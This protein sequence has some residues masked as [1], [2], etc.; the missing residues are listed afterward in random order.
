MAT[1]RRLAA[2]FAADVAG[3]SRLMEAD[4]DGTHN[5]LKGLRCALVDPRINEHRGRVVKSTGDGFLAEFASIID[6]VR[7]AVEMQRALAEHNIMAP[8]GHQIEFRVGIN[9]GDI[10]VEE[11]D[12]Y[13]DGVNVAARLEALAD[14]GGICVSGV[15]RDQVENKLTLTFEDMGEQRVKN[16]ARPVH[17]HRIRIDE[18]VPAKE[19]LPSLSEPPA[20]S[21]KGSA[22]DND[23]F[24]FGPFRLLPAQRLLLR[25][26]GEPPHVGSR[27]LDLLIALVERAGET[28]TK[29]ELI[30]RAWP[31][32]R[33]DEGGLRVH[34]AALRRALGDGRAGNRYII[35]NPGRGYTFVAPVKRKV[36]RS[37]D[38]AAGGSIAVGN[39]PLP[40]T[41]MVGRDE[42]V[43]ALAAQ[44]ARRRFLSIIGPGGIGKTT[45]AVAVAAAG[46]ASYADGVWFVGLASLSDPELV[47]SA[48]SQVLG[49]SPSGAN[50]AAGVAAWLRDKQSLI[51]LDN[52]EHVID[53]AAAVAEAVLRTAP[54]VRILVTSREPLR[55][56]GEWS[57]RLTSLA[58]P[59]DSVD[60]TA[61]EALKYS[62]VQLFNERAMAAAD[63]F[64]L[65][66][67][68]V[69]AVLEICRR[70]D[71]LPL[72]LELAAA[73]IDVFG[74]RELAAHLDDRFRLLTSGRRTALSRHQTLGAALDWSYQLLSEA[75]RGLLRRLSLF[76]GDFTL[77]AAIAIAADIAPSEVVDHIGSLVAKSLVVVDFRNKLSRYRLLDT[78]R[79]YSRDKL[80][81]CGEL[82][83]VARRHA[84]HYCD[85]FAPAEAESETR[86]QSEW[87][88]IYGPQLDNV[89]AALD[90]AFSADGDLQLGVALTVAAVPLWEQLS[91][92]AE[93]RERVERALAVL[94]GDRVDTARSRMQLSAAH[95]W[96]LM[97]GVGRAREAGPAWT[98][99]LDLAE[100]L[101]DGSY[102]LRALWSLCIDQ[103]NN[104]DLRSALDFA[105]RFASLASN[106][107]DA[108]DLMMAD[109]LLATAQHYFGDQ[110]EAHFHIDR[111]LAQLAALAQQPQ[112]VRVRFDMRVSTHYFQARIL[113]LRGLPDQ[114]QRV[115]AHNIEEG[116]AVG[117][118]L[119][120]CSV[121]GQG[122]CPIALWAGDLAAAARYA[123]MLLHHTERHPIRLWNIWARCFIGLVHAKSGDLAEGVQALRRGFEDAGDA[124]F[125]PRFLL[126]QGEFAICLG[127]AGELA[128]GLAIIDETLARCESREELWYMAELLR[129]KGEL[130]KLQDGAGAEAAAEGYFQ[131]ALDRAGRQGAL[132]LELR[133][134]TSLARLR[135]D[136]QRIAEGRDLL[137]S[138]YRRFTEGFATTDLRTAELLLG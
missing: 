79:L 29:D 6:A 116:N 112:I 51:V 127:Q 102:R 1:T 113:W 76:A 89:R 15:V 114:A 99:T 52:C 96:S 118:A 11:D 69:P 124:R 26:E 104:G 100:R 95:G 57:H 91:L 8:A 136:Q 133:A 7:C 68:N 115:V 46:R 88:A 82:R 34:I 36:R 54:Q 81:S 94:E 135:K 128:A 132:S 80:N 93:C 38:A 27:A 13:G 119:S 138:V 126:L 19:G 25:D 3:Y 47:P 44:L 73:R 32:T 90:W 84:A 20:G 109:R 41:H 70:L 30:S 18:T 72:A 2:I 48:L 87:L 60:L 40:L 35:N 55:A 22:A 62:A 23:T 12:I 56:E 65:D 123:E 85:L 86:P 103:F 4:E 111:A 122:A 9:L 64:V 101:G 16:I 130:V 63:R 107:T 59:P 117:Q 53:A 67:A 5:T 17:V 58:L 61:A 21:S 75:E 66:D 131:R 74:V 43:A 125:L 37:V 33:V 106:S 83:E 24:V 77:D 134:A 121:L 110:R 108:I 78:T 98:T 42:L 97:Y 31:D 45:V 14:S 49:L 71:G 10:I 120:F 39:L 50:P 105:R 92:F 28:I 129:I 137:S